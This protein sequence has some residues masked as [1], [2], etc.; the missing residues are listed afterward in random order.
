MGFSSIQNFLLLVTP[1]ASAFPVWQPHSERDVAQNAAITNCTQPGMVALTYD[2]GPGPYT[3]E[4]LDILEANDVKATFFVNG[5]NNNGPITEAKGAAAIKEVYANGHFI[6]S[7]T[8]SHADLATLSTEERRNEMDQLQDALGDLIGFTP[9]Y[10]RPPY[11]SCPSDCLQ[12][13]VDF[14][15][16]VVSFSRVASPQICINKHTRL[17]PILTPRTIGT[18]TNGHATFIPRP[19]PPAAR[20]HRASSLSSTIFTLRQCGLLPSS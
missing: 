13:M 6:G 4:L 19:W 16:S 2:D 14:G 20:R 5:N 1:L 7:H 12:D 9:T 15:Y 8:W 10:M 3:E 17:M 18:I 11:F